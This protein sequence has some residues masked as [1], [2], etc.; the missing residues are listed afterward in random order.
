MPKALADSF[1]EHKLSPAIYPRLEVLSAD[2][3]KPWQVRGTTCEVPQVELGDYKK[4]IKDS[5]KSEA[6]WTP[7]KKIAAK[8]DKP[9]TE[10]K[11]QRV[12]K[13]LLNSTKITIPKI[14][15]EQEVNARL[16]K[17]LERIE[18][19]GLTLDGY[20]SSTGKTAD[21]L[22]Q[23]Y[24]L[25]VRESVAMDLMLDK[26]GEEQKITVEEAKI[27]EVLN[28]SDADPSLKDNLNSPEQRRLIGSILRRRASLDYLVS[29][30]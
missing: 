21:Q 3:E 22:R 12:L 27:D 15:V 25:Q 30:M 4:L 7:D 28:A 26:V 2:E 23:E 8:G 17:L 24:E 16:S 14:L 13:V 11:Q 20:L 5:S 10:E 19:L 18:K 6:I 1:S 29:L 9:T